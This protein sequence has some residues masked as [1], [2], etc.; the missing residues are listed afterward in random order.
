MTDVKTWIHS[1][2]GLIKG[3]E[4]LSRSDDTWLT[5]QLVGDHQL[6]YGSECN[7]GRIDPDGSTLVVRRTYLRSI[8]D[9]S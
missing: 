6:R 3:R 4:L 8:G 1:R 9:P 7:R 5:I 2:K